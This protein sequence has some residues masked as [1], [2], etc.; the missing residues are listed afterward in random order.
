MAAIYIVPLQTYGL[1]GLGAYRNMTLN[2]YIL[3]AV[4]VSNGRI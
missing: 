2:I 3:E 1:Q 4:L